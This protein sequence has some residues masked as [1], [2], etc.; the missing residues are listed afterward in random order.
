[1]LDKAPADAKP[2]SRQVL[3][4]L[5]MWQRFVSRFPK[6]QHLPTFP[7]WAMEFGATYP[8]KDFTPTSMKPSMLRKYRGAYGKSLSALADA[9]IKPASRRTHE[10]RGNGFRIG[11]STSSEE[12]RPL[13]GA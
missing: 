1:M 9:E 6:D 7:I 2:L 11:R 5:K 8:Y 10:P 4:C 13:P 3:D 12:S